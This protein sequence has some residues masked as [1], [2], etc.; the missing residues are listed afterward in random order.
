[1]IPALDLA[2]FEAWLAVERV[3]KHDV[4]GFEHAMFFAWWQAGCPAAGAAGSVAAAA[5]IASP[6]ATGPAPRPR[7]SAPRPRP[8][9]VLTRPAPSIPGGLF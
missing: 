4:P 2:R 1:M 6:A 7:A 8:T 9:A 3:G 5:P